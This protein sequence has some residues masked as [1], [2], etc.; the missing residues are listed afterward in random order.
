MGL[1]N[2]GKIAKK[3]IEIGKSAECP[4]AVISKGT[5]PEQKVVVGTLENIVEKAKDA[6][7]PA[8]IIVGEVVKLR[9]QLAWFKEDA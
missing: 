5:T 8:M 1:H 9:E 2:L 7:T 6:Q 3:L 4:C